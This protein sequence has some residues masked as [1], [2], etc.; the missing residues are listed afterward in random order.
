[1]LVV[2]GLAM[3]LSPSAADAW[4]SRSGPM[5]P[6]RRWARGPVLLVE[7]R[8]PT[9]ARGLVLAG[10]VR[11]GRTRHSVYPPIACLHVRA[12]E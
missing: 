2:E 8:E 4:G 1:M 3:G 12:M 11:R 10:L 9:G 6:R 5:M 7:E